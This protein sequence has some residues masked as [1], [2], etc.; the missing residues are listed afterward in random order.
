[1]MNLVRGRGRSGG[2]CGGKEALGSLRKGKD[3]V[4]LRLLPM[5]GLVGGNRL[6]FEG[7]LVEG[8]GPPRT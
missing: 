1:M 5:L 6:L 7:R 3:G 4:S 2:I 8:V